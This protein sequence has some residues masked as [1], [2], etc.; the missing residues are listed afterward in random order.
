MLFETQIVSSDPK[1]ALKTLY[2]DLV[3]KALLSDKSRCYNFRESDSLYL[4]I[5]LFYYIQALYKL[6]RLHLLILLRF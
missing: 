5:H 4:A 6:E 1:Q 2:P 3:Q